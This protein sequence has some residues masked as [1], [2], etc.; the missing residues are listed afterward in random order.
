MDGEG[1]SRE[2]DL[3]GRDY[4]GVGTLLVHKL[5]PRREG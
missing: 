3:V 1:L 5:N 2:E 4:S